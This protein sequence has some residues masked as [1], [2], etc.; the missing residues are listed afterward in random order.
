MPRLLA[1]P[2]HRPSPHDRLRNAHTDDAMTTAISPH[3]PHLPTAAELTAWLESAVVHGLE[4]D[5]AVLRTT[6]RF[7]ELGVDSMLAAQIA[8]DLRRRVRRPVGM[9]VLYEYPDIDTL[10]QTYG[11]P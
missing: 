4:I 6:R 9:N 5:P 11:T 7:D 10:A 2:T 1:R 3:P 8:R